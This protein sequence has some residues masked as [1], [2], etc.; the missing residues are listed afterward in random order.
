[1]NSSVAAAIDQVARAFP[2][3]RTTYLEDGQGGAFVVVDALDLGS[4][5]ASPTSWVGFAISPLYPRADVYPHFVRPDLARADG[6]AL[7]VPLNPGQTMP[8]FQRPATMVSRRSNR[9]DPARDTAAL[10]LHRVLLW[11]RE[12][13]APRRIAA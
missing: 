7:T 9:W 10:K 13:A 4:A 6:A 5:F 1:M 8:G 11:F 2:D 3:S 12:Q